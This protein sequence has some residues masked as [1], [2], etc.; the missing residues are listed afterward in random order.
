MQEIKRSKFW[1]LD[2][3][4]L[5][6]RFPGLA[7]LKSSSTKLVILSFEPLK[8]MHYWTSYGDLKFLVQNLNCLILFGYDVL[9][10]VNS[11]FLI[12]DERSSCTC[13]QFQK[14]ENLF[15]MF[16]LN[17]LFMRVRMMK[18]NTG[19]L[20]T[21][22]NKKKPFS[23]LLNR[24]LQN[25]RVWTVTSSSSARTIFPVLKIEHTNT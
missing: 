1:P 9:G 23:I 5:N 22:W 12:Y 4:F 20:A 25:T 19:L 24:L 8:S 3:Q 17:L 16:L 18:M 2:E 21:L 13:A 7:M 6:S 14:L 15:I 11:W 10:L